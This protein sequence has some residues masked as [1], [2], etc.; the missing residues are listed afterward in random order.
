MV[1]LGRAAQLEEPTQ[2]GFRATLQRYAE[3]MSAVHT[4]NRAHRFNR[5]LNDTGASAVDAESLLNWRAKLIGE[6]QHHLGGAKG[7]LI[8]WYNYGFDGVTAEAVELLRGWRIKGNDKGN[9]VR[10]GS[11]TEGPYTDI[12]VA[13]HLTTANRVRRCLSRLLLKPPSLKYFVSL[14]D[15]RAS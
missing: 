13:A 12:E 9:A 5:F 14:I 10:G 6:N 3:E 1:Y 7:F 4:R 15:G 11:L 2:S 8:V